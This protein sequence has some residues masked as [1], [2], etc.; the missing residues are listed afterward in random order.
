MAQ[1]LAWVQ[2]ELRHTWAAQHTVRSLDPRFRK[3]VEAIQA[4][5]SSL[6]PPCSRQ[7]LYF[8]NKD[9]YYN[10]PAAKRNAAIERCFKNF[11]AAAASDSEL[12]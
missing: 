8:L 4:A 12:S 3:K 2:A 9:P 11:E 7:Q 5:G 1:I 10:C 6:S